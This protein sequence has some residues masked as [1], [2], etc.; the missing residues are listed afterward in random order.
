MKLG[1]PV[2]VLGRPGLKAN[3]TRRWQSNPHLSVSL[4]YLRD[5]FVYL[6]QID[7]HM[8]RMSSDLAPYVTHPDLPQFHDQIAECADELAAVGE[9]A[10]QD[11]LRL[12]FH[13]A[14]HIV[15]NSPDSAIAQ[16]SIADLDAQA[17]M[18]ELMGLGP[19]AV[20]VLHV[21]GMYGDKR[22][23]MDRF[24]QR[25]HSLREKTRQR[26]VLENDERAYTIGD[27]YA[28][29]RQT[30]IR[31]VFDQL[32]YLCNPIPGM[33]LVDALHLALSTWPKSQTPKIHYSTP[34][35]SMIAVDRRD[36]SG[37]KRKDLREPRISQHADL[38][39]PFAF[40]DLLAA[41]QERDF[42][43]MLEC[44]AK[45]LALLRLRKHLDRFAPHLVAHHQIT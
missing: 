18:L 14:A 8:Y 7:V 39:D 16:K 4:A 34:R 45:D 25:Y 32:H 9:M 41:V 40:I 17:Q 13:P 27:T 43:V 26:L 31:L 3:D 21:G 35:T 24:V 19:E 22:A 37:R 15:L 10:R 28:I 6:R 23:A 20:V 33:T 42:D 1:F 44:K 36:A 2:Q 12:S 30:G 11:R 5:I 38:I 29:H